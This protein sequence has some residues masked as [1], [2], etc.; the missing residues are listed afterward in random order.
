M[1]PAGPREHYVVGMVCFH[2]IFL[3]IL[4][5]AKYFH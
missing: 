1:Q 2:A 5:F 3:F 4:F